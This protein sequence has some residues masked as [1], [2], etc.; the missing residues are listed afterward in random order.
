MEEA[1]A[2]VKPAGSGFAIVGILKDDHLGLLEVEA[3]DGLRIV[4][5]RLG[6]GVDHRVMISGFTYDE[7]PAETV[8]PFGTA[9]LEGRARVRKSRGVFPAV[10]LS[11][12]VQGEWEESRRAGEGLESRE[13]I[14]MGKR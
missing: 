10:R 6:E 1:F 12:L 13:E 3:A 14:L 2:D 11:V 5:E 8:V 9:V 7:V 4:L